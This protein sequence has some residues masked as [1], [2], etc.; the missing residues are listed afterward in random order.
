MYNEARRQFLTTG[1]RF[2]EP[3]PAHYG[4]I[5]H[6]WT[7]ADGDELDGIVIG[8]GEA[9]VGGVIVARPIGAMLRAD[10]DH[11]IVAVRAD[12]ASAYEGVT[13]IAEQPELRESIEPIFRGRSRVTGWASAVEAR[14]MILSAQAARIHHDEDAGR[15]AL[16]LPAGG[17]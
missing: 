15:T 10:E 13:D 11:K 17:N 7:E 6:T 12:L 4:W 1:E 5:P 14:S 9:A 16:A 2:P 3:L 8:E